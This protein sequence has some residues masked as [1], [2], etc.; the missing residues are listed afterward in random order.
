M[1]VTD[2]AGCFS[3]TAYIK[4]KVKTLPKV[5]A[6]PDRI[7]PYNTPFTFEPVYGSNV[8]KYL[9]APAAG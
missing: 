3:D 4:I 8:I 2:S 1:A 6:G 5:D 9:W 7:Y